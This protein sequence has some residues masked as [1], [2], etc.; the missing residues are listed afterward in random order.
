[1]T[2]KTNA[3]DWLQNAGEMGKVVAAKDWSQT[4]LGSIES[5]PQSLR[6]TVSLCLA[7]NFPISIAWGPER[8]QIYNDG[9][10]PI[11]GAKHPHSMGQD[12]KECWL[13]AWPV[14]GAAFESA[15]A[16]QAAFLTNQRLFIDRNGYL[17]ETY[18]TF[19]FS[20]IHDESGAIG[21][22]F[23]PVIE[24]TQQSL[25]QR[26]L[27][28]LRDIATDTADAK[29]VDDALAQ[30]AQTLSGYSV[31]VPFALFYKVDDEVRQA[32]LAEIVGLKRDSDC[33]PEQVDLASLISSG[34]PFAEV[35]RTG[36]FVLIDDL[37]ERFEAFCCDPYPE[38]PKSA[39]VLPLS[40]LGQ[41][42]PQ[43]LLVAGISSRRPLDEAYGN[44]YEMLGA[45]ITTALVKAHS[46]EEERRRAEALA[47][48]D[49]S[50]TVFF[51]NVSHEFRTPLTLMLG[52][53]EELQARF[54][55]EG[56]TPAAAEYEQLT[57]V[58][59]NGLRLLK[60]VNTLLDF[61][62][63]E[64]GRMEAAY[65]AT[66]LA[67]YTTELASVFGSATDKAGLKL[68]VSC[69]AMPE[70]V[71]VDRKMWEKIVLN[72]LSNAFKH[73]FQGEIEVALRWCEKW[74]ELAVRDTGIGIAEDQLEH[75][76]ER[77]HRVQNV[78]S[79]SHEG[80]GIGL[81]L[82][83]ELARLHGGGVSV[84]SEPGVGS[85]F[86]VTI[87]TGT[88][89]LQTEHI[90]PSQAPYPHMIAADFFVDEASRWELGAETKNDTG[91]Q[92][93]MDKIQGLSY[94]GGS[95]IVL[96][97]D[98]SDMRNYVARLLQ[99]Q[100]YAVTAVRDGEAALAAVRE[101]RPD[102]VL[103]DIM[104]PRLD[105]IGLLSALRED[106]QTRTIPIILLSARAGEEARVDG[107]KHGADSYMTKPFTARELIARVGSCLEISRLR[108]E[109]E[110]QLRIQEKEREFRSLAE[111]MPQIVWATR[112]DGW[113]IYFNRKWAEYT[114]LTLEESYGHGWITPFHPDDKQHAWDAWEYAT[115]HNESYSLEC[116]LRRADG[117]YRWW[118]IRGV[119][120]LNAHGEIQKWY[121]TCTDIQDLK[122]ADMAIRESEARLH[123]ALEMSKTG[124][125][126]VDLQTRAAY[127]SI[128][129]AR[130]FGYA[131]LASPWSA[132]IFLKHVLE[133]DRPK[134]SAIMDEGFRT[135]S[136]KSFECRI[137][138]TDGV[139]RWIFAA[140]RFRVNRLDGKSQVSTGIIQDITERKHAQIALEL[141]NAKLEERVKKRTAELETAKAQAETANRSKSAF[142]ANMSHEIR[143]P[144]NAILGLTHVLKRD[145]PNPVQFECIK[146]IDAAGR[147]LLAIINDILDL[148]KI[149]AGHLVLETVDFSLTAILDQVHDFIKQPALAKG[150]TVAI[151][152]DGVPLWLKGD[153]TRLGQSLLNYAGNAVK[154]T[155][156]GTVS[157]NAR[158]LGE[159]ANGLWLRF[160]VRDTGPGI[161]PDKLSDLFNA[162]EQADVS[163][164]RKYGGTGLGLAITR[165]LAG[166]MGGEA[167]VDSQPGTGSTFWF[168]ARLERGREKVALEKSISH[169]SAES[170]LRIKHAGARLLLA[171]DNPINREVALELLSGLGL[172]VDI[173]EDGLEAVEKVNNQ[174]Y[175]LIL[176][177]VQ[178]PKLDGLDATKTI[179]FLPGGKEIPIL[180]MTA[181][182]FEEDR[183][184]CLKAGMNDFVTK[185]VEPKILYSTLTKWLSTTSSKSN[186]V[187]VSS[188]FAE[189]PGWQQQLSEIPGLDVERG[190]QNVGGKMATYLKVL[191]ML[192][193]HHGTYPQ[194]LTLALADNDL[195]E[196]KRLA[197]QLKGAA[198]S[199]GATGIE[200]RVGEVDLAI[201]QGAARDDIEQLCTVIV[202][203]L[204]SIVEKVQN[205]LAEAETGT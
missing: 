152:T 97:D 56:L 71:Y 180:A 88:A 124:A 35:M 155:E 79:R 184:E 62:R 22:L 181:N 3:S 147:H 117:V 109:V 151:D 178:M 204:S 200:A 192:V 83:Q 166:L 57:L 69:P 45:S 95:H 12:F 182:A 36:R 11:C 143:T 103:T 66:D 104:M 112:P 113:N 6:T 64:A 205:V 190:L 61:S 173:A 54:A 120:L 13:S 114:G 150:L 93:A 24:L 2:N 32:R 201:N 202:T 185:P 92:P 48:L 31:D 110:T 21:G 72:L 28:V 127:R 197:H 65:E 159:D 27:Q 148:S 51:S 145:Q 138:R 170:E 108:N 130:I 49:R 118:L 70:L 96:A 162:F 176:M 161:A 40:F 165:R 158:L 142:L 38:P 30:L 98:N 78:R 191:R 77:F 107:L 198:G 81:A 99:E 141:A 42:R 53:L 67:V 193:E 133:E 7:S 44:F 132:D 199:L 100:G 122:E 194:R 135:G 91:N 18:F 163:T 187:S 14:I 29:N 188:N 195:I 121:G 73:T 85:I 146:K 55:P 4:P 87:L 129:H 8:T 116:R 84:T 80:S 33:A 160:E 15:A 39:L 46:Y 82:V 144:M 90:H 9:Y 125:W 60:L 169:E 106:M 50:K 89:H 115:Q 137:R 111:T 41:D 17:E 186:A 139:I 59:R 136:E 167:G 16:G 168:T 123:F 156:R 203:E 76:F 5:W 43:A 175:D 74:V 10:W 75:V 25:A 1:M 140:G 26:R 52:P 171:E 102:L 149:E 128:E 157:L 23:H 154:F 174:A 86:T 183:Q 189:T 101:H 20:P 177:D 19:S 134:V 47:E 179:R 94:S 34:W 172:S 119:P 105:G 126:E 131:D 37:Q 164:T 68:I 196:V 153:P 63:I 58:H